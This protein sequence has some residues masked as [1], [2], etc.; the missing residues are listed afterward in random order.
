MQVAVYHLECSLQSIYFIAKVECWRSNADENHQKVISLSSQDWLKID[1]I[2]SML[3]FVYFDQLLYHL[4][5]GKIF[6]SILS[7]FCHKKEGTWLLPS[8][9]YF[10]FCVCVFHSYV[11]LNVRPLKRYFHMFKRKRISFFKLILFCQPR[12]R[13]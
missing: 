3:M 1:I 12:E 10:N 4:Q 2:C 9:K 5:S 13:G 6:I 8:K 7:L 11:L